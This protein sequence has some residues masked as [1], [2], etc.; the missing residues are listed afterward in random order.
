[1]IRSDITIGSYHLVSKLHEGRNSAIYRCIDGDGTSLILKMPTEHYGHPRVHEQYEFEY[2]LLSSLTSEHVIKPLALMHIDQRPLLFF[3]DEQYIGLKDWIKSKTLSIREALAMFIQLAN[4]MVDVHQHGIIHRDINAANIIIS[5]ADLK[6]KL[7]DFGIA[8]KVSNQGQ[9]QLNPGLLEGTIGYLSPE[10]T[11]RVNRYI[12]HRTDFYS[13]GVTMYE[14]IVGRLPYQAQDIMGMIHAHIAESPKPPYVVRP[15]IPQMLSSI[16]MKCMSKM[17]EDRYMS[18]EGLKLDLIHCYDQWQLKEE[19]SPFTLGLH[20]YFNQLIIPG[21]IYGRKAERTALSQVYKQVAEGSMR[22]VW[23]TGES[24]IGKTAL[25]DN[26]RSEVVRSGG[27]F[28]KGQLNPLRSSVPYASLVQAFQSIVEYLLTQDE[29][30]TLSWKH[31]MLE[32]VGSNG[33]LL[34]DLIPKLDKLI[35]PQPDVQMLPPKEAEYRFRF[36]L[37]NFMKLLGTEE[38]PLVIFL[39]DLHWADASTLRLMSYWMQHAELR[40]TLFVCCY[41]EDHLAPGHPTF[42]MLAELKVM[43]GV[44]SLPLTPLLTSDLTEMLEDALHLPAD[45]VEPLAELLM[46]KTKGSPFFIHQY[47]QMLHQEQSIYYDVSQK[48]WKWDQAAVERA[49]ITDNVVQLLIDKFRILPETSRHVLAIASCFGNVFEVE[50]LKRITS[51]DSKTIHVSL[52]EAL[53][54]GF[55]YKIKTSTDLLPQEGIVFAHDRIRQAAYDLL[56]KMERAC[57]HYHIATRLYDDKS[58]LSEQGLFEK[59]EHMNLSLAAIDSKKVRLDVVRLN[60]EAGL[61]S[62]W[63]SAF[64]VARRYFQQGCDLLDQDAWITEHSL[65]LNLWIEK[66]EMEFLCNAF[67]ASSDALDLALFHAKT[68][69]QKTRIY[70]IKI[71][72]S[73]WLTQ[74]EEVSRLSND[75]LKELGHSLPEQPG[76]YHVLAEAMKLKMQLKFKPVANLLNHKEMTDPHLREVVKIL[77]NVG[78][79]SYYINQNWFALSMLRTLN[80]SIRFGNAPESSIG[81]SSYGVALIA[82]FGDRKLGYEFG[83]LGWMLA[84]KYDDT[85]CKCRTYGTFGIFINHWKHHA[86]TNMDFLYE[87]YR[88][89]FESGNLLY[90]SY[91]MI[92]ILENLYFCGAKLDDI[93]V[94]VSKFMDIRQKF[95]VETLGRVYIIQQFIEALQSGTSD[96]FRQD[97]WEKHPM[98]AQSKNSELKIYL[99]HLYQAQFLFVYGNIEEAYDSILFADQWIEQVAGQVVYID[100]L[101]YRSL[102]LSTYA[103]KHPNDDTK[104]IVKQVKQALKQFEVWAQDGPDNFL[105]KYWFIKGELESLKGNIDEAIQAYEKSIQYANEHRF[106]HQAA[107]VSEVTA[108]QYMIR[109]HRK[110]AEYYINEAYKTYQRWGAYGKAAALRHHYAKW[111][112]QDTRQTS[113]SM[114]TNSVNSF[115]GTTEH[116]ARMLDWST[117]MKATQTISSEIQID[118]FLSKMMK[119]SLENAG[120]ERAYFISERLGKWY[121]EARS[122][123][124]GNEVLTQEMIPLDHANDLP[125]SIV[126]YVIRTRESL[127][128]HN[129]IQHEKFNRDSYIIH[130]SLKSVMCLPIIR[131]ETLLGVLYLDNNLVTYAFQP[132]RVELIHILLTQA[133]ISLENARLYKNLDDQVAERTRSLEDALTTI[134]RTQKQLIESEKMAAL[135]QLVAGVAHEINTP[136]GIGI[137]ASSHLQMVTHEVIELYEQKRINKQQLE[138]YFKLCEESAALVQTNLNRAAHLISSFKRIAVDQSSEEARTFALKPYIE[139]VLVSLSPKLKRTLHHIEIMIDEELVITSYPGC[140]SQVITNLILNSLTHAFEEQDAGEITIRVLEEPHQLIVAYSDNGKGMEPQVLSR[141]YDP[142]FTTKRGKGGTG[143]GMHLVYNIVT[144]QLNGT[145]QCRSKLNEGTQFFITIPVKPKQ[146]I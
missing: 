134:Q 23:I 28:F 104:V 69:L 82:K 123:L 9:H 74:Y 14:L 97:D 24:G 77:N 58:E 73:T 4:A 45:S 128:I 100:H 145:I 1:M 26:F 78:P 20:D 47:L 135:G 99:Y 70:D 80:L 71:N 81:Y 5:P 106:Y 3:E 116:F 11:G 52:Q 140:I 15:D 84:D 102:I 76:T 25:V 36:V 53:Q 49:Q 50:D 56:E 7:I 86:Y 96:F 61:R 48:M 111:L 13:L 30:S 2:Q 22:M 107:L 127:I 55:I 108:K 113:I 146:G 64:E 94:E 119:I 60:F 66:A 39:D 137:T 115:T 40:H 143:L 93:A 110:L 117:V 72:M 8:T 17:A 6:L 62:K 59:T 105:N 125:K 54:G 133:A 32:A 18:A 118:R 136:V 131:G 91:C 33:K 44:E 38:R 124:K 65:T 29:P 132:E 89:G 83:E 103:S 122:H 88:Y 142:F 101:F 109:G 75:I 129:A 63:I 19:I 126:H 41:R 57:I 138:D 37:D 12:D 144:Q 34:T 51:Y 46:T 85:Y 112:E 67:E 16:I 120:A 121:I 98:L 141:I 43:Q 130:K 95:N 42:D 139:E 68:T 90:A 87:A 114:H 10:Q 79:A 27:L 35:G 92:A 21:S 31:Q